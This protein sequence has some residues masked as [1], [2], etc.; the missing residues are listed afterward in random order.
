M[1]PQPT[2]PEKPWL[3]FPLGQGQVIKGW[4]SGLAGQKVGSRV[5][6]VIPPAE[7]YGTAGSPPKIAG[8]DTLVFVVDILAA[9]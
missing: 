9:Y 8:T 5:L 2:R 3:K 7:G 6:L 4:D 1:S